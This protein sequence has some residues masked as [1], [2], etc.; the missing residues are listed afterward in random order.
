MMDVKL[1]HM[2]GETLSSSSS[3]E[4]LDVAQIKEER[5][6]T[7]NSLQICADL[8]DHINRLQLAQA[9]TQSSQS[10]SFSNKI[11]NDTLQKCKDNL[12]SLAEEL[13]THEKKLF[14]SLMRKVA[15][16]GGS[17]EALADIARLR[18]ELE[19]AR[20]S[21]N[22]VSS[23]S[24][25]LERSVSII[26]NHATGDAV[27]YMVSTNGQVLHGTNR[28]LGWKSRQVGGYIDSETLRQISKDWS[29]PALP[30]VLPNLPDK[31]SARE[32]DARFQRFGGGKTL[33][34]K[35][36]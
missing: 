24:R 4:A 2:L 27:Q 18:D 1:E 23:A 35:G 6:S 17:P 33:S 28:S 11:T 25:E 14:D 9:S 12:S 26:E 10:S 3:I 13:M 7:E 31:S 29:R 19:S 5:Q 32:D 36:L 34:P 20:Q 15:D 16:T 22:L 21:A 8:S 30:E